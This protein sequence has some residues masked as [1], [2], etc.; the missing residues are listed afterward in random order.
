MIV[1]YNWPIFN[2][3]RDGRLRC[4]TKYEPRL[5]PGEACLARLGHWD[6]Q[7]CSRTRSC[8]NPQKSLCYTSP[9]S[10]TI[11]LTDLY[12]PI[13]TELNG[14][15]DTIH[16]LWL[17]ALT[18]VRLEA[19][20]APK[21]GGKLLRPALSLLAAGAVGGANLRQY[22][23]LA[24]AFEALHIASLAHDDVIDRAI[25][26]RGSSSLNAFWD[27][28]AAVL[29]G[30]YLVARAVEM[31]S[32]YDVCAVVANAIRSVR[33]MAEGELYFFGRED[34]P[35][36]AEDCI[37]LAEQKTAS[38]F[39][40]AC[41]APTYIIDPEH[42][43]ALHQFGISLGIAFQ[44]VDDVLDITQTT[45]QLGKPACGDVVEGKKTIPIMHLRHGL[46]DADNRRLDAMRNADLT[47]DDRAW[48]IGRAEE[49]GAREKAE[50]IT[51]SYADE[52]RRHLAALPP[53]TY[54]DSM[55]GIVE[56]V[57]VRMS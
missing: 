41:S 13:E 37:M 5:A 3:L 28:H 46:N 15:R 47:E 30:D 55:E 40:E 19:H 6:V 12:R 11:A 51:R 49:T 52:A 42:R 35:I 14:V 33:C 8:W 16:Q 9:V 50:A 54:R 34:E 48:I 29:G 36:V 24:S 20:A 22:V 7:W 26:R 31:L 44:L 1:S 18:L 56:F 45:E 43:K 57:V 53:S 2:G 17:D 10:K 25:L 32:T 4:P 21:P 27:N 39:A 38:L 23:T